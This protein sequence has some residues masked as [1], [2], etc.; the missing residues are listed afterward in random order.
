MIRNYDVGISQCLVMKEYGVNSSWTELFRV[1]MDAALGLKLR[2]ISYLGDEKKRV[3][4]EGGG[5]V[6]C[7]DVGSKSFIDVEI[8]GIDEEF[9]VFLAVLMTMTRCNKK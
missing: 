7:F 3:I 8:D 1:K 2:P 6:F 4:L 9:E 5:E